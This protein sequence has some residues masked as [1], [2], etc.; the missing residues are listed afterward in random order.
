MVQSSLQ[1]KAEYLAEVSEDEHVAASDCLTSIMV[2]LSSRPITED[3]FNS[4][5]INA[6]A[7]FMEI[8]HAHINGA[9][10]QARERERG[11]R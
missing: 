6:N 3:W 1:T 9:L 5:P 2:E 11:E 8:V 4:M 10:L 7:L